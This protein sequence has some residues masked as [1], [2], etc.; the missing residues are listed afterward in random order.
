MTEVSFLV[1]Y[2]FK[3]AWQWMRTCSK[4][5]F[6]CRHSQG[7]SSLGLLGIS[8][9]HS[10]GNQPT[11]PRALPSQN[12]PSPILRTTYEKVSK[13]KYIKTLFSLFT[14][15]MCSPIYDTRKNACYT[16]SSFKITSALTGFLTTSLWMCINLHMTIY[17]IRPMLILSNEVFIPL[18]PL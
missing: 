4:C 11:F 16:Y 1:Y 6:V 17:Y 3:L 2:P 9:T 10:A 18:K 13:N 8:S 12:P 7:L 5:V 15:C 14:Y